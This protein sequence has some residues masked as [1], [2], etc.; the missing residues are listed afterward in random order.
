M[1]NHP[2]FRVVT[3]IVLLAAGFLAGCAG[4][5]YTPVYFP[6]TGGDEGTTQQPTADTSA[7]QCTLS[8]TSQLCVTIK[9]DN[10]EVGTEGSE[11]LCTEVPA[12]P[13]H[14]SGT[15]VT[16]NGSEFP[17][18]N[19][20]GHGLPAPITINARGDGD[21]AANVG[22]GT[23]DAS[24]NIAIENFSLFI[25]ALGIVGEVPGLTLTTG[26]TEELDFLPSIS[27]SPPDASGAGREAAR[28]RGRLRFGLARARKGGA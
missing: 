18:I 20:E 10:I 26:S 22:T 3:V 24:G 7:R 2:W 4:E 8:F 9:G 23:I 11:P 12:F 27:G 21:G 15:T 6:P 14:V 19:V 5:D 16:L 13:L 1:S 25:V 28:G 17:D